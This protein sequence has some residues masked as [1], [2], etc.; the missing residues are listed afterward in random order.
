[1]TE[2]MRSRRLFSIRPPTCSAPWP[3][4]GQVWTFPGSG[5]FSRSTGVKHA[6]FLTSRRITHLEIRTCISHYALLKGGKSVFVDLRTPT[7]EP[8]A[9]LP[10]VAR[11]RASPSI[12]TTSV[13][14]LDKKVEN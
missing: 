7:I 3:D 8:G 4:F 5:P 6:S 12:G 2:K 10:E 13:A 11:T 1:M 9:G 14:K